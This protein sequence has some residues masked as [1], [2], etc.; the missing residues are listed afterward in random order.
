MWQ[1]MFFATCPWNNWPPSD[2]WKS[3][4]SQGII[5]YSYTYQ[6]KN[7][8]VQDRWTGK[9]FDPCTQEWICELFRWWVF[10][11]VR[12]EYFCGFIFLWVVPPFL[13]SIPGSWM[14]PNEWTNWAHLFVNRWNLPE[15][16]G[17]LTDIK[18]QP[19]ETVW[20]IWS[21]R[22][23]GTLISCMCNGHDGWGYGEE[24]FLT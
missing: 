7:V 16:R 11:I 21:V 2:V 18:F 12:T 9:H 4:L 1:V 14:Y 5:W 15:W 6:V 13:L 24:E 8:S 10:H 22:L 19:G 23:L 3:H 20:I 17:P